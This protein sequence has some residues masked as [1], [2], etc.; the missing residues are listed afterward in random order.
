MS[1]VL[2]ERLVAVA[3]AARHTNH[4]QKGVIYE[5]AC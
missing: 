5:K 4:G 3:Q 1:A 2:T